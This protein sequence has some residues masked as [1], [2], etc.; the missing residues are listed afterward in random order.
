M[1][2]AKEEESKKLKVCEPK[3]RGKKSRERGDDG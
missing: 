1:N 3:K 2:Y